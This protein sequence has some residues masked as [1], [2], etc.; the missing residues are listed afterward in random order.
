M[1]LTLSHEKFSP[2]NRTKSL[3]YVIPKLRGA[4]E[5]LKSRLSSIPNN[6]K[7]ALHNTRF[8][9]TARKRMGPGIYDFKHVPSNG[10]EFNNSPRM[11]NTVSHHISSMH[12]LEFKIFNK[13]TEDEHHKK[14]NKSNARN[15]L[16]YYQEI[17]ERNREHLRSIERKLKS[18]RDLR[19]SMH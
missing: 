11:Q 7:I 15:F 12:Y 8:S 9:Y 18:K 13:K 17:R 4:V 16:T 5:I 19:L 10:C 6:E 2:H 3:N 14:I 1:L